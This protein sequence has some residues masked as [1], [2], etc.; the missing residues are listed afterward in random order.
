MFGRVKVPPNS[1]LLSLE[2]L[3]FSSHRLEDLI[4]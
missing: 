4:R 1:D 2:S 3:N